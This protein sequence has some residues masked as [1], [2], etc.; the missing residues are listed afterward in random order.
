MVQVFLCF[1]TELGFNL[2][3]DR[4]GNLLLKKKN[5]SNK[6]IGVNAR[7]SWLAISGLQACVCVCVELWLLLLLL[8]LRSQR[9]LGLSGSGG[10]S[11][12]LWESTSI[13]SAL[14]IGCYIALVFF[15]QVNA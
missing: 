4:V 6:D 10:G 2:L 3:V 7:A 14:D 11:E 8:L 15:N 13:F 1:A 12:I 5:I 9:Y